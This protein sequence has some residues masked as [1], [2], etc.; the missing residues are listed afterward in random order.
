[1]K[2]LLDRFAISPFRV[3]NLFPIVLIVN[4]RHVI[5]SNERGIMKGT[6]RPS[7]EDA[8]LCATYPWWQY[9]PKQTLGGTWAAR[10]GQDI[11]H[12]EC[13]HT[14]RT[15]K[16]VYMAEE[17]WSWQRW[18][19]SGGYLPAF[20]RYFRWETWDTFGTRLPKVNNNQ[21][22]FL[23]CREHAITHAKIEIFSIFVRSPMYGVSEEA[24]LY[25][26][27]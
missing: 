3:M 14:W 22:S 15:I 10:V 27:Q 5:Y 13:T 1:M 26:L 17:P 20:V 12:S 21:F 16:G 9:K 11:L 4:W 2:S 24:R 18:T 8:H 6:I 23:T 19:R 7:V 25:L